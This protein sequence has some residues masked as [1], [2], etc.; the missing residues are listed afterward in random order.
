MNTLRSAHPSGVI[1]RF[2][3]VLSY[4]AGTGYFVP[5]AAACPAGAVPTETR[6][7]GT[8]T[9]HLAK[10]EEAHKAAEAFRQDAARYRDALQ[11]EKK[12][13]AILPKAPENPWW[14]KARLHYEPLIE[15]AERRAAEAD[16]SAEYHRFRAVELQGH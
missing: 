6:P 4:L 13:I 8:A 15:E 16:R 1:P 10:A 7:C 12:G 2:L 11:K 3:P 9:A 14:R 5:H